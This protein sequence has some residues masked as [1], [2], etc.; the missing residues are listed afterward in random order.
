MSIRPILIVLALLLP[1]CALVPPP[2]F[3]VKVATARYI[4]GDPLVAY[5]VHTAVNEI[6][7][8]LGED[9]VVQ[10]ALLRSE[11]EQVIAWGEISVA[12][13]HMLM[14]LLDMVQVA[15]QEADVVRTVSVLY[16][17]DA[18]AAHSG[19][20]FGDDLTFLNSPGV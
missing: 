18:V 20:Y 5:R 13:Q 14:A 6:R 19:I 17:L 1:A 16:V 8:L 9:I 7:S 15:L 11:V 4:A 3:A 12:R 10:V 2:S